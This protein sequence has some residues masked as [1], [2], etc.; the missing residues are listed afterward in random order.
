MRIL[1]TGDYRRMPW[2][3][4]GGETTEMVVSPAAASLHDFDWR[5]SM[6]R[7][8][9]PGPFS[10]FPGIER[11]LSVIDGQGLILLFE[12]QQPTAL[13]R[14]SEPFTFSGD[15][16]VDSR[17]VEGPIEDLNV[18]TRRERCR[19]DVTKHSL[20]SSTRISLNGK[21]TILVANGGT[22]DIS[23]DP[24]VATLT[25]RDALVLEPDEASTVVA[26]A[27]DKADLFVIEIA[28]DD[29]TLR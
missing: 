22:I 13:D 28:F 4:G 21:M 15:A 3:N 26:N 20:T 6:A 12:D 24:Q 8:G 29:G 1:R 19:H 9:A 14:H 17:L 10:R 5:V 11:T 7:V 2:K 25:S 23:T 18:M 27:H 16:A